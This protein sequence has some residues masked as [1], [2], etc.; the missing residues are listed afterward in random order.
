MHPDER[1]ASTQ[2]GQLGL[3]PHRAPMNRNLI[4]VLVAAFLIASFVTF[5]VF[6]LIN[7]G[8]H[9]KNIIE[10]IVQVI[11]F[12]LCFSG[13]EIMKSAGYRRI[14]RYYLVYTFAIVIAS[15]VLILVL[16]LAR[17][18]SYILAEIDYYSMYAA[19]AGLFPLSLYLKYK[20]KKS[21]TESTVADAN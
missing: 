7:S 21:S 14:T 3:R 4:V 19:L 18:V 12:L 20:L 16:H 11:A 15:F 17:S 8:P 6:R 2:T 5:I 1:I 10:H 9:H 13:I